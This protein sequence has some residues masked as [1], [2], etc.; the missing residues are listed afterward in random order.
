MYIWNT[1]TFIGCVCCCCRSESYYCLFAFWILIDSIKCEKTALLFRWFKSS[2]LYVWIGVCVRTTH[3]TYQYAVASYGGLIIQFLYFIPI[4]SNQTVAY[5]IFFAIFH[6]SNCLW[7][8]NNAWDF[9][10]MWFVLTDRRNNDAIW[11][12]PFLFYTNAKRVCEIARLL[13]QKQVI[14]YCS[15]ANCKMQSHF[16]L[17]FHNARLILTSFY[18][19]LLFQRRNVRLIWQSLTCW[20]VNG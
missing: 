6:Q 2:F 19:V 15:T 1:Q 5:N 4:E 7:R 8:Q 9:L 12:W 10:Y 17:S 18:G 16:S 13:I 14:N 3:S 20:T 11:L